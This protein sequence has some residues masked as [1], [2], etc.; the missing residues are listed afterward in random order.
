MLSPVDEYK[1]NRLIGLLESIGNSKS[2]L[3]SKVIT[4]VDYL[5][6]HN[7]KNVTVGFSGGADSTVVLLLLALAKKQYDFNIHAVTIMTF[8]RRESSFHYG[9]LSKMFDFTIFKD[10]KHEILYYSHSRTL[11]E[12]FDRFNITN[13]TIHQSYYQSMYN[14]LFTYAQHTKSITVGTTNLDE[15]SYV[16]W[17]GKNSDMMVDLQIISDLHKFEIYSILNYFHIEMARE[18]TGDI[19]DGLTDEE[20]FDT[21]YNTLSYYSYCKCHNIDPGFVLEN[22]DNLHKENYHK[23]LGQSFNP[24]FLINFNRSFIYNKDFKYQTFNSLK[25]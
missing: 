3:E 15:L 25:D 1:N 19:P 20:Y 4:I 10:I 23:Y 5:K 6:T 14:I 11:E 22:V 12:T 21:D 9:A 2:L 18:P 8:D 13:L 16:G 7:I 24:I 17:F